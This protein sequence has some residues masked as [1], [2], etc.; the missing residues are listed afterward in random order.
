M[1][2]LDRF[3]VAKQIFT[4]MKQS[5]L[6]KERVILLQKSFIN[7]GPMYLFP[8]TLSKLDRFKVAKQ[9]FTIVKQ[10]LSQTV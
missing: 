2:K 8:E 6:Q 10:S 1:S 3:K 4:F 5:L 9:I 7:I